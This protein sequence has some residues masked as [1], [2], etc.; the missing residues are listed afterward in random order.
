METYADYVVITTGQLLKHKLSPRIIR[1]PK[2]MN[3]F[4]LVLHEE[5]A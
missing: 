3:L 2:H 1:K 4:V 5:C